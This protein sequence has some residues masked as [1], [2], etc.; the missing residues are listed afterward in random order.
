MVSD[1]DQKKLKI[2]NSLLHKKKRTFLSS[3]CKTLLPEKFNNFVIQKITKIQSDLETEQIGVDPNRFDFLTCSRIETFAPESEKEIE[4][5]VLTC[6]NKQCKLDLIPTSLVKD[7][8]QTFTPI[9]T[10]IINPS[11][12]T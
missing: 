8:C 12:Q 6:P 10:K 2:L 3:V 1:G 4:R 9:F 11:L 5:L 7:C